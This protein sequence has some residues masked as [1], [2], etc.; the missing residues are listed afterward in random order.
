MR[1]IGGNTKA[2]VQV[3]TTQKNS[4]GENVIVW[5][6][7]QTLTG[8]LDFSGGDAKYTN[9]NAKLQELTYIFV[10]DYVPLRSDISAENS[11]LLI[12]GKT[13]DIMYI[14]NPMELKTGSQLEISLK[15]TGRQKK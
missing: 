6:T 5:N 11:R 9:Y 13:Y 8:W 4:I 7:V 3:R 10:C 14:D 2:C 15:Y 12:D 1:G